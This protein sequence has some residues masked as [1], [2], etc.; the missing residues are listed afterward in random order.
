MPTFDFEDGLVPSDFSNTTLQPW[1]N[2]TAQANGGTHSLKSG[3]TSDNTTSMC[4]IFIDVQTTGNLTLDYLVSS[5]STFDFGRIYVDGV[6][7]VAVSGAGSWVTSTSISLSVGKHLVQF[8]YQKDNSGS[9]GDDA[10][11]IDNVVFPDGVYG[12]DVE[13]FPS[14]IPVS[15]WTN[16]GTLPWTVTPT[17]D[18]QYTGL[19]SGAGSN[20][21]SILKYV[22]D[23]G[24]AAGDVVVL[25]RASSE[26]TF[27]F[28]KFFIDTVEV[29]SRDGLNSFPTGFITTVT[30]GSHTYEWKY[31]KDG[32]GDAGLDEGI[33]EAF[34]EPGFEVAVSGR[35]MGSLAHDGGLVGAGGLAG[36]G[37]GLAG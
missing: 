35:I 30:S 7:E 37:G 12:D 18:T 29:D 25:S 20:Q 3:A 21:T 2:S 23:S 31:S 24:A 36:K 32:S 28:L 17:S 6:E 14:G 4:S 13:F 8:I 5:E 11:Y 9:S 26:A 19:S 1:V 10:F 16:D 15:G 33:L 22:S 34:F 27:D